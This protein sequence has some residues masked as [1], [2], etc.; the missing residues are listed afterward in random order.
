MTA[1]LRALLEGLADSEYREFSSRLLP[2]VENILGVRLD[3]LRKL[4]R[5]LARLDN[6]S[7]WLATASDASMEEIMLQGMSIGYAKAPPADILAY[8]AAFVPK[9]TNWSVN[10]SFCSSLKLARKHQALFWDFLQPYCHSPKEFPCR[11]GLIMLLDHFLNNEYIQPVLDLLRDFSNP[12]YYAQMGAAWLL[13]GC[14]V[15]SRDKTLALLR[16]NTLD[17]VTYRMALQKC[18]ESRRVSPEDKAML[19]SMKRQAT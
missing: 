16:E 14:Y 18:I 4:A 3:Q 8:T 19:R 1:C 13:S 12:A 10:D 5:S 7:E 11:F 6:W 17:D 15:F 2:G 9:I